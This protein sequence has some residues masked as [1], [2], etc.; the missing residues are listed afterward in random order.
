MKKLIFLLPFWAT[1]AVVF[2][3]NCDFEPSSKTAKLL[4]KAADKKKYDGD[5]RVTFYEEAL[6]EDANCLPCLLELGDIHFKRAKRG[7]GNFNAAQAYL[8]QLTEK[9]EDYHSSAW[10]YLGAIYYA[11]HQY[12]KALMAFEKFQRFPTDDPA[13]FDKDYDKKYEEVN[14]ALPFVEFYRDFYANDSEL[15]TRVVQGVSGSNDEYLP[16]LSPDGELMFYTRKHMKQAKGDIVAKQVEEFTWSKRSDINAIFDEGAALPNP[17]NMGDNYGGASISVDNKEMFIAKKNP[18]SGNPDN[19]DIY[20]TRYELTTDP[21]TGKKTY[22]W[23]ELQNLGP[24]VNTDM[25]WESQPSLSGDGK[26]LFFATVRETTLP[27]A[28]GN[29]GTDIFYSVRQ[30]DGSW[31]EA[32]PVGPPI[33]TNYND[34]APFMHSDSHTMYFA[35]DRQPGGGGYDLW[36][37]R[38]NEDGTWSKPR[39]MGAPINT[40]DDEHGMIVSADGEQAYFASRRMAGAKGFDIYSFPVPENARPDKVVILKGK[41]EDENGD[42][43]KDAVVELKYVQSKTVEKIAV[44]SDDG[45]YATI[46]NLAKNEDVV[47][48]VK[49]DDA[50]FNTHLVVDKEDPVQPAVVK[51]EVK[52]EKVQKAKPFVIPDIFYAT[53]STDINRESKIILDEFAEYL[54]ANPKITVEIGGHTDSQG[55]DDS[56]LALSMDRAFEIKGYLESMG[57]SGKRITAKGYGETKPIATNDTEA[58]RAQNRRTE[59]IITGM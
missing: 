10:Y 43:P 2:G 55:S 24:N 36:Y 31:S 49:A 15:A 9:C 1:T 41:V 50:A 34:K 29:P 58:G 53:S 27:D 13:K 28:N 12:D 35:S 40:D 23:S 25:G 42:V 26:T 22:L 59:F 48:S 30:S 44:S 19:I 52:S 8:E 16:A 45:A 38:Q 4:E 56:N 6:D 37:T 11:G 3:Q 18:V 46:V 5:Q 21:K 51:L 7:G 57:I 32:K 39:N 14:G 33:N 20:V 54:K 17:F 47:V